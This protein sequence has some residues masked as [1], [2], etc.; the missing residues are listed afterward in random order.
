MNHLNISGQPEII[1]STLVSI[2]IVLYIMYILF[3]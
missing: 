1:I 2:V 3:I